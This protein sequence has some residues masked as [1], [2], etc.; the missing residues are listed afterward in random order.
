MREYLGNMKVVMRDDRHVS[1]QPI[2][3]LI[4]T[5]NTTVHTPVGDRLKDS[6]ERHAF[7]TNLMGLRHDSYACQ[8]EDI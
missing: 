2:I 5:F 3:L 6:F 4:A 1:R 8:R 7:G